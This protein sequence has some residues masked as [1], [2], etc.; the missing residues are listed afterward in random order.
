MSATAFGQTTTQAPDPPTTISITTGTAYTQNFDT[1]TNS[2]VATTNTLPPPAGFAIGETI[3]TGQSSTVANGDYRV[4]TG[5]SAT[6]DT[7]SF[8]AAAGNTERA[9][10]SLTVGS[11]T[12]VRYGARFQNDTGIT[13]TALTIQYTG[14]QWRGG[15]ATTDKLDFAHSLDATSLSTGIWVDVDL[16]DFTTPNTATDGAL[17]GNA[18]GNR[19]TVTNTITGLNIPNGSTFWIRWSDT[20]VTGTDDGLSVDDFSLEVSSTTA[21]KISSFTSSLVMQQGVV[22][23]WRTGF[24]VD[25][26]GF[27][28]YRER[29]GRRVPI[30]PTI[31]A[32]SALTAA[33]GIAMAAGN[34]YT[35]VDP[36]GTSDSVYYLEDI[37]L[38]GTRTMHGPVVPS[39]CTDSVSS[40]SLRRSTL[41][42]E[43]RG[44]VTNKTGA[45]RLQRGWAAAGLKSSPQRVNK[46]E[47]LESALTTIPLKSAEFIS[48]D[49]VANNSQSPDIQKRL[50]AMAGLKISVS[51]DGWHRVTQ[52]ALVAAGLD[53]DEDMRSLKLYV[54]GIEVPIKIN[55]SKN[56][57]PLKPGDSIEFYGVA[58]DTP[59]DDTREYWL[60]SGST[61]GKRIKAQTLKNVSSNQVSPGFEY[62]IERKERLLY[63]SGLL[64]G[65]KE[66]FFGQVINNTP[67]VQTLLV[68]H[69]N[70]SSDAR[71]EVALQGVTLQD[72]FVRVQ[73]N[74]TELGSL[75]FAGKSHGL[76]QFQI[77]SRLLHEGVN[78][79]TLQRMNGDMDISLVDYLR[80]NYVHTYQ[81]DDDYLQFTLQGRAQLTGFRIPE[82]LLLDIT[83]PNSIVL[84]NPKTEKRVDG[85]A[86]T[87]Q[88]SERRTFVAL[89][90]Q[91]VISPA[92][93]S[94]NQPST[95]NSHV[96][97]ADFIVIT[98]RDFR[99]NVGQ[100]AE[101]RRNDGMSVAVVDVEDVYDEF[102]Y[103]AH[104][105]RAI[106]DFLHW[107][108]LHWLRA[109]RFVLLVGDGSLDPRDYLGNGA[110]DFVPAR[111]IDTALM[112]TASDDWFADFDNDGVGDIAI[113]RLPVRTGDEAERIISR[114]AAYSP[115]NC[116]QKAVIIADKGSDQSNFRFE[117]ASLQLSSLLTP[118][119]GVETI[120]RGEN[121]TSFVHDQI[122][123]SINQGPLLVNFMGHGSVEVW[124]GGPIFSSSDAAELTNG[125]SLP[126]FLMMTCLNG[127]YQDPIR[128]SLAESLMRAQGGGAIAVWASSGLTEPTPQ[129]EMSTA[130]YEHLFTDPSLTLGEVVMKAKRKNSDLDVRRTWILFGDPTMHIR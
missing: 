105:P 3:P 89:T 92:A 98:H 54:D 87:L 10:G 76:A 111:L 45:Q 91:S 17:D 65:D 121:A 13:I 99:K 51:E 35:W 73:V 100:L 9:L 1:L 80:L 64:N 16:L 69:L 61:P 118:N 81:A 18:V 4:G 82:V 96:E 60:V 70:K 120:L 129:L 25:N 5:S 33:P 79:V 2:G 68:Q 11:I 62:I 8:G 101:L 125:A 123:S 34:S 127:Y 90:E 78:T 122:M 21:V 88:A 66:N 27:N 22:V 63:F 44:R 20:D 24:E 47:I 15:T 116:A 126:V 38:N 42:D 124:T 83:D 107:S 97:G 55:S 114:I 49:A 77:S 93:I 14:E 41:L 19:T 31:I 128:E 46:A 95:W 50:A 56:S 85:Y 29:K 12:P 130:F 57:G 52:P 84:Y 6:G 119:I 94:R 72:H 74:G 39:A 86:F 43:L 7:Y 71:L 36:A 117:D 58:L 30:N 115:N 108:T 106:R 110:V 26:L 112:E 75:R 23:E 109:P 67:V 48:R 104:S 53:V 28:V 37:D 40:A 59:A 113:G 102:N 103:G 32:G